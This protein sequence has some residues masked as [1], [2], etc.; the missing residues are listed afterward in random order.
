[1]R[2]KAMV[3]GL[4]QALL[5][6]LL[7]AGC[8]TAGPGGPEGGNET[9]GVVVD[10]GDAAVELE[11]AWERAQKNC[12]HGGGCVWAPLW[13][14][15]SDGTIDPERAATATVRPALPE[16]GMYEIYAWWCRA[17]GRALASRQR[18]WICASRGYS[19]VA[20]YV[21]PQ[22]NEGQ[23]NSLGTFYLE[24]DADV[25]VKNSAQALGAPPGWETVA[26]GAVVVDA[27]R[28]VYRGPRPGT[29]TPV[30]FAPQPSPTAAAGP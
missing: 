12:A 2:R 8:T 19:C 17:P 16:A 13:E 30:P 21:N 27:F 6:A 26:D 14:N 22:E 23:W 25:T 29:L 5:L 24:T 7:V 10:D 1:M 20:V 18:V 11:G 4:T 28:F 3:Q 15:P 9:D